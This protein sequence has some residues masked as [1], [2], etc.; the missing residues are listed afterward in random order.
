MC[1]EPVFSRVFRE[2]AETLHHY[3]YYKT[4]D[5]AL[6]QDLTQEAFVRMWKNCRGVS[7]DTAKGYVF[8]TANNLLLNHHEHQKV[9]FR[10]EQRE[11]RSHDAMDPGFVMEESEL[12]TRLEAAIAALPDKQ[13]VAF[14]LSRID[15]KTYQEIADMEGISTKA[16]EKRI[17]AA[18]DKLRKVVKSIR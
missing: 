8:T 7:F 18:L 17:Y 11:H 13:R 10:F 1:E 2:Y 15:N 12:K 4:G 14:L 6:A 9:V 3:L 16:V 5:D